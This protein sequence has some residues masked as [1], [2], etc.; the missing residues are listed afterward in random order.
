MPARAALDKDEIAR[1]EIGY[2]GRI[3]RHHSI[4]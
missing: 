4:T 2:A 1:I 3:E